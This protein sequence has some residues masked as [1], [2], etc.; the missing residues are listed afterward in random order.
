M[1]ETN[2]TFPN[3]VAKIQVYMSNKTQNSDYFSLLRKSGSYKNMLNFMAIVYTFCKYEPQRLVNNK[4]WQCKYQARPAMVK[5]K[6]R[7]RKF[8]MP[9]F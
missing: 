8:Q 5:G 4:Q 7:G 3:L 9:Y 6:K 2:R 1:N